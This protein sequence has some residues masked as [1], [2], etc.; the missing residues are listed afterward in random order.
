MEE[1]FPDNICKIGE[2]MQKSINIIKFFLLEI[3]KLSLSGVQTRC[4]T[5]NKVKANSHITYARKLS[6]QIQYYIL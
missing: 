3:L 1:G 4:R 6:W 5:P 2:E